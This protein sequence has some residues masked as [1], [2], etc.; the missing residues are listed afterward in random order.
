MN[1]MLER[2]VAA[3]SR[4]PEDEQETIASLILEE[5]QAEQGWQERFRKSGG[6]LAELARRART[7]HASGETTELVFPP[8]K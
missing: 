8:E 7:Q 1:K 3:A 2:A 6:K 4:L 5:I